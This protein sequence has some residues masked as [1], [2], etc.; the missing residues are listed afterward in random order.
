MLKR[1]FAIAFVVSVAVAGAQA[2]RGQR[3]APPDG[4]Q[5]GRGG[6]GGAV[7]AAKPYVPTSAASL[8][9]NPDPLIGENVT[10][11]ASVEQILSKSAF[12]IVQHQPAGATVSPKAPQ[13]TIKDVLVLAPILNAPVEQDKYVTVGGEVLRFDPAEIAKKVK[14]YQLD[15]APDVVE[16]YKGRPVVIAKV[17]VNGSMVDLAMRLPPPY[18]ADEKALD[19]TMKKVGPASAGLRTSVDGSKMENTADNIA[20]LKKA[21]TDTEAFWKSKSVPD[22]AKKALDARVLVESI[23]REISSGAWDDAK[24]NVAQ[25]TQACGGCHTPYR[26]RFDDGSFRAKLPEKTPGR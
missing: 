19:D 9:R 12:L 25:L 13:G 23:D 3:G 18:T 14:N 5:E 21:F 24:K 26:E 1:S 6:R 2:Q 10:V 11:T 15:L 7:P 16:K 4:A 17:V 22:A 8:A 20:L